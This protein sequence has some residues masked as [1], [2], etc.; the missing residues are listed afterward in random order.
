[1]PFLMLNNFDHTK[2]VLEMLEGGTLGNL[3]IYHQPL[4]SV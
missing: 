3:R 1:M 2:Y 4:S